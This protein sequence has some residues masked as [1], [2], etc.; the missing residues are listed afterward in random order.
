MPYIRNKGTWKTGYQEYAP[1]SQHIDM[2][3]DFVMVYG[4]DQQLESRI[5]GFKDQGYNIHFMTGISWGHY[6]DYLYGQY[7]GINHEDE[8]QTDVN[9]HKII[10]G[11][12]ETMP[13]MVPTFS[14][15]EYLYDKL[16]K[17]VDLG[18]EAIHLEEPEFWLHA[19]YS[20]AFKEAFEVYYNAPWVDQHSSADAMLKNQE[21]KVFLYKRAL[22]MLSQKIKTYSMNTYKKYIPVYVP[23]HSLLNYA[24]WK[25]MSPEGELSNLKSIDGFIAQVWTGTSREKNVFKGIEKER[26]FE[27]AFLE[28]GVMKAL[29]GQDKRIWF[30]NDPIEDNPN[31]T[32]DNYRYNYLKTLV[33][34]LLHK[35]V[36]DYEIC[37]WPNRIFNRKLP[38]GHPQATFI[39]E[40]YDIL[41]NQLFHMLGDMPAITTHQKK[42]ALLMSDTA[43]YQR[44]VPIN[45][46]HEKIEEEASLLTFSDF[47]GV[48]LPLLKQGVPLENTTVEQ[49][50]YNDL[51]L[52]NIQVLIMS[53]DFMKPRDLSFHMKLDM[54]L[55]QGKTIIF[56]GSNNGFF[57]NIKA[58]GTDKDQ[59]FSHLIRTLGID[60]NHEDI[61]DVD[62]GLF[63]FYNQ[64]PIQI[65]NHINEHDKLVN[66]IKNCFHR[67]H[68][69]L[70]KTSVIQNKRGP[71]LIA[72]NMDESEYSNHFTI[73]GKY[74]DMTSLNFDYIEN[75]LL[76]IDEVAILYD[77]H[78]TKQGT[79]IG[80]TYRIVKQEMSDSSLEL[81]VSGKQNIKGRLRIKVKKQPKHVNY[82]FEFCEKSLTILVHVELK[83]KQEKIL[84]QF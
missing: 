61:I 34:S 43:M 81:I 20:K 10:H 78:D 82:P 55:K 22:D 64:R 41:L 24:Q 1:W 11:T 57:Q 21:L 60:P 44:Q 54:F 47:Y 70:P 29:K 67:S 75:Y 46:P 32:W 56:I 74:Y 77:D 9:G 33:A 50:M 23:T 26:T 72:A 45:V 12:D 36:N 51:A 71:Y 80:T 28:Y 48:A 73:K 15:I 65:A 52:N 27:T 6:Q 53:Y 42:V 19:G 25:I 16:K 8:A 39:P 37:P 3:C 4:F 62:A 40:D 76:N 83:N 63:C 69:E 58:Y 59:P 49:I 18:V 30:L 17:V 13:Y 68:F 31:Y 5:K 79:I 38:E 7:D 14:Y 84:I 35:E 66:F 2:H